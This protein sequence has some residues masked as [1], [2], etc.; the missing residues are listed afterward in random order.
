MQLYLNFVWLHVV[1]NKGSLV[2]MKLLKPRNN[3]FS[4]Q[5]F[6]I[7]LKGNQFYFNF[8]EIRVE[9]PGIDRCLHQF[10][11]P[12]PLHT[13]YIFAP[14][15]TPIWKSKTEINHSR[16][17]KRKTLTSSKIVFHFLLKIVHYYVCLAFESQQFVMLELYSVIKIQVLS[18]CT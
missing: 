17:L 11:S 15:S 9:E 1:G 7:V 12:L 14:L 6:L 2:A 5:T 3:P 13:T 18:S 10:S 16:Y 4:M 8:G